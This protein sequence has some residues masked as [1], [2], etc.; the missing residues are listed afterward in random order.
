[1]CVRF[2][3]QFGALRNRDLVSVTSPTPNIIT[4]I[5][6]THKTVTPDPRNGTP[7]RVRTREAY[8][9]NVHGMVRFTRSRRDVLRPPP[10][11]VCHDVYNCAF[12][13]EKPEP[14]T[15]D[16]RFKT[17]IFLLKQY[18]PQPRQ[19]L[20][21]AV[22]A[23]RR[24]RDDGRSSS[25]FPGVNFQSSVDTRNFQWARLNFHDQLKFIKK[26]SIY[27]YYLKVYRIVPVST[28][29]GERN[30]VRCLRARNKSV[31]NVCEIKLIVLPSQHDLLYT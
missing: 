31:P 8:V 16:E 15:V 12:V 7:S 27:R 29:N 26:I 1:M 13:V 30:H 11:R 5:Y 19:A 20:H 17:I 18:H 21:H 14:G 4:R 6:D 10:I 25:N 9:E 22:S 3:L 28:F 2:P 23:K 24:F